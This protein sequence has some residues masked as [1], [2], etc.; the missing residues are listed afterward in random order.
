MSSS[1]PLFELV[2]NFYI[3]AR[4]AYESSGINLDHYHK[5]PEIITFDEMNQSFLKTERE[6]AQ[7]IKSMHDLLGRIDSEKLS[8][9]ESSRLKNHISARLVEIRS[10]EQAHKKSFIEFVNA[11]KN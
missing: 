1:V 9:S 8:N 11:E 3:S 6:I 10:W 7:S 4:D 5:N 2:K